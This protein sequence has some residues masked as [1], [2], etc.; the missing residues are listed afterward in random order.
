[1]HD[2]E[3]I[4]MKELS[5]RKNDF[6]TIKKSDNEDFNPSLRSLNKPNYLI[7]RALY[8]S[9]LNYVN[10]ITGRVLDIGCGSKPYKNMFARATEYVGMDTKISGHKHVNENIDIYYDGKVFPLEENAFD[11]AVCFQVLEHVED[12]DL[13]LDEI[14]RVI[15]KNGYILIDMPFFWEEHEMPYDFR[16]LT[17]SGLKNILKKH[18]FQVVKYEKFNNGLE[19]IPQFLNLYLRKLY[20][21]GIPKFLVDWLG[22]IPMNLLGLLLQS[23]HIKIN[24]MYGGH[25][26]LV[27]N[28]K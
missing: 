6:F 5:K 2:E 3:R 20:K 15:K 10:K 11:N 17:E 12:I 22:V 23:L 16:R 9:K 28:M 4:T 14:S 19:L 27:K 21:P 7:R 18:H 24:T 1:V 13:F 25:V 8:D 26:V